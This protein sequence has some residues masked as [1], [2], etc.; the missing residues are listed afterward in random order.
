VS[1]NENHV[2]AK[3][4]ALSK[5]NSQ[6]F[7]EYLSPDFIRSLAKTRGVQSGLDYAEAFEVIRLFI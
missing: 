5:Y 4:N 3:V 2:N 7:R 6:G 1:L